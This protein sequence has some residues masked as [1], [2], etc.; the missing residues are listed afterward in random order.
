MV[1]KL[2]NSQFKSLIFNYSRILDGFIRLDVTDFKEG[3]DKI[4]TS[5]TCRTIRIGS[6]KFDSKDSVSYFTLHVELNNY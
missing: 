4:V 5:L 3:E 6:Y 1:L 2:T